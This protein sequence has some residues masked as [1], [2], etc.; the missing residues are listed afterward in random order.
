MDNKTGQVFDRQFEDCENAR[1][2]LIKLRYSK[3]LTKIAVS[4]ETQGEYDYLLYRF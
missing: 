2:F 1:K 4:T 3:K